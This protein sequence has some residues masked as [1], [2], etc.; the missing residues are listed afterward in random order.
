M[1]N[2]LSLANVINISLAAAQAGAGAYSNSNLALFT[3]EVFAN[4]F[5]TLGYKIYLDPSG[6]GTDFG[7]D[8]DTF[9]MA[10]GIFGQQPNILQGSGY[11]VV[12]PMTEAKQDFTLSGVPASGSFT[13]AYTAGTTAAINWDDNAAAIQTKIRGVAGFEA[14]V[15]TGTLAAELLHI[16]Y[17]G[18]YGPVA[19]PTVGGAGLQTSV[20]A[21]ITI[22]PSQ[23][24]VGED[25]AAAIT[26]TQSL[27]QYFGVLPVLI[28]DQVDTLAAAAVAQPLNILVGMVQ[29]DPATVAPDGLLDLLEQGQFTHSR[30]LFYGADND[31]DSLVYSASYFG[32]GLSVNFSGSK[33]T[34]TMHLKTLSAVLPDPSMSQTLLNQCQAAGA[35]VYASFRGV[36][37]VFTSG[38][39]QFFDQVYNRGWF[40]GALQLAG[41]NYLAEVD[42]KVPQTE[43]GMDGLKNAYDSV[44]AQG[45]TNGYLAPGQWNSATTFGNQADFLQNI[46]QVGYYIYSVPIAKQSQTDRAARKSP[47]AQIAG[48]EAGAIQ[49]S[50]VIVYINP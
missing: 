22:T 40:V 50:D 7:T 5:G 6:V 25:L 14:A 12:I 24:Q 13:L 42:T 27:V 34:L 30:A 3:S 37:K 33:T 36:E 35:D 15:V 16:D 2:Q 4:S 20:P 38:A 11:L 48:K 44:C 41:F 10:N 32:R 1:G 39:N 49:E 23:I 45:V 21:A 26:R 8:S 9:K 31:T 18:F 43:P 28:L 19:V 47:L 29:R 46:S 17:K